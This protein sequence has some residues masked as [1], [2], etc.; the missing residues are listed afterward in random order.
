VGIAIDDFGTGAAGCLT[1]L[2]CFP[3]SAFKIDRS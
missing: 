3:V 1:H 2:K